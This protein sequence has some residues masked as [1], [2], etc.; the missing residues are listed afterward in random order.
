MNRKNRKRLV[1]SAAAVSMLVP[2]AACGG[3]NSAKSDS[4]SLQI[5]TQA[6]T[7]EGKLDGYVGKMFKDKLGLSNISVVPATV[8]GTDRFQTKLTTGQLGDVVI[9]TSRDSLKKAIDAGQVIDLNTIKDQL[10]N[11]FRFTDAIARM[12]NTDD[13]KVYAIPS[14]VAQTAELTKGDPVNVPSLRYDYY[15]ELGSPT[16]KDYWGYKDVAEAMAKAHP[17][18]ENGDNFYA[19]SL[20]GGWDSKSAGQIRN[21]ANAMGWAIT[22]GVNGYDFINIDPINKRTEDLLAD[23]GTYLQGLKWANSFHQDGMLDPDSATQTWDDYLKKGEKG[24]SAM[25]VYGYIGN[26][27]F[28]PVNKDLTEQKKGYERITNESMSIADQMTSTIGT[29]WFWAITKNG[30]HETAAKFL[31]YMYGDE[32]SFTYEN[33]PEGVIWKMNA[34]GKP[35]FTDLGNSDWS[36]SVPDDLGGGKVQD[37]FKARVNG[38][39]MDPNAVDEKYGSP[40]AYN[41]WDTYLVDHASNLD[42]EWSADHDG[43]I[44]VKEVLVNNKQVTGFP[45]KDVPVKEWSDTDA[46]IVSQVGDAIK[47]YSWKMIYANS[48]SEFESLKKEMIAKAKNLGYDKLVEFE[49]KYAQ[50]YFDAE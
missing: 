43:A 15:K 47:Q 49:T 41:V 42:K 10:P 48:D 3:N 8:G 4:T 45:V 6:A 16:I 38:S 29:N 5:F 13:G 1:A 21:I 17:K 37:T 27:N 20:F 9:F 18:T 24:Q 26:L 22:D 11:A 32:G 19:L 44:N 46:V 2:L 28:N 35:E 30:N 34:D 39:F 14:G 40:S 33:G 36:T 31:N 25:W 7:Y 12:E 23:G 50:N